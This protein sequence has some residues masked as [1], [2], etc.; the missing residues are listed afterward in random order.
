MLR[1]S[2]Y[3]SMIKQKNVK[4][5][6]EDKCWINVMQEDLVQFERNQVRDLLQKPKGVIVIGT[7]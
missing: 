5:A 3:I 7:K 2:Y 6:L 4:E 1:Q